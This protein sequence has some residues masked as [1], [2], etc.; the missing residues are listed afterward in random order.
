MKII[1]ASAS[2]R[3]REL[4]RLI[5]ENFT[6]VSTDTDETLPPNIK[7]LD[8]SAYLAEIK[9]KSARESFPDDIVIGCDTMVIIDSKILGKPK[10]SGRLP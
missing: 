5:T 4:M 3:R 9:A 7:P 8:A 2:P 1:L 6:A 10:N